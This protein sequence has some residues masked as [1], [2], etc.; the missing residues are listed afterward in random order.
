MEMFFRIRRDQSL[1]LV[2]RRRLFAQAGADYFGMS[3]PSEFILASGWAA[4]LVL[5]SLVNVFHRKFDSDEMQHLH[6]LWSWTRGSVQYRDVFDNHMPL[7]HLLLAPICGVIG[8]RASILYWMRFILLPISFIVPWCTYKI[9][10]RLFS[11]RA[12]VWAAIALGFFTPYNLFALQFR[13]DNLVIPFWLL[14][15]T[16][17]LGAEITVRRA[18]VA[19]LL[20]GLC[21]AVSMKSTVL[22]LSCA[23][24]L[25]LAM[26]LV[27]RKNSASSLTH[28]VRCGAA[29]LATSA[30]VPGAIA[31]FFAWKGIWPDFR[32]CVVDFNF[33]ADELYKKQLVYKSHPGLALSVLGSG[34]ALGTYVAASVLR[35]SADNKTAFRRVFVLFICLS[36]FLILKL[37]WPPLSRTYAG[38]Y[39][40]VF[41]LFVAG[42]FAV[43]HR[44]GNCRPRF[45]PIVQFLPTLV[46]VVEL[47]VLFGTH[48]LPQK[49]T[50]EDT[51]LLRDVLALTGPADSVF[52]CKGETVFRPRCYRPVLERITMR[53][54]RNGVLPDDVPERCIQT[55]NCVVATIFR[56]RFSPSTRH[57]VKQNYLPVARNLRVAGMVLHASANDLRELIFDVTIPADYEIISLKSAVAG[58][59]D[60]TTYHGPRFLS[61]GPH[62][63]HPAS[64]ASDLILLWAQAAERHY[65]PLN[66]PRSPD[67]PPSGILHKPTT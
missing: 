60:G 12:G 66:A 22:L 54:I 47:I 33:L 14:C 27:R 62:V 17:L 61:A 36:Y 8:P 3:G 29:F 9:G 40:L 56:K 44:V 31:L 1:S 46:L 67:Q 51:T 4:G 26:A 48:P 37:F 63:F 28:V 64:A 58:T 59:L 52:D 49:A 50:A 19:G 13:P 7:F 24:G 6:V 15:M 43:S 23:I 42:L 39:P 32:Y 5:L 16:V 65:L 18:L 30:L 45:K 2:L 41:A 35:S 25:L 38:L 57:F 21:F 55:G 10:T 20:L 53:A 11:R 34:L